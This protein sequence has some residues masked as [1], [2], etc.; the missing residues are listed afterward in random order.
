MWGNEPHHCV[1][2]GSHLWWPKALPQ[3]NLDYAAN[4]CRE[5]H[6][7]GDSP[8]TVS[9]AIQPSGTGEMQALDLAVSGDT[10]TVQLAGGQPGRVYDILILLTGASGRVW[11][12]V[13]QIMVKLG[14]VLAWEVPPAPV[15]TFG[16]PI[17]WTPEAVVFGAPFSNVAINL[18]A[19][20]TNQATALPLL[21]FVNEF[22]SAPTGTA[23]ILPAVGFLSGTFTIQNNDPAN[24]L[25]VYAPIGAQINNQAVDAPFIVGSLGGRISFSTNNPTTQWV[26]G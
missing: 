1:P 15:A 5:L 7:S 13:V 22:A 16:I 14:G 24:N 11:P 8:A 17:V 4:A 23:C 21:A 18:T 10:V 3:S 26:A 6:A 12:Y 2:A 19:V 25:T 9:L 20:G